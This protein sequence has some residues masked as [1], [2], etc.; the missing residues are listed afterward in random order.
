MKHNAL[1]IESR[2]GNFLVLSR[3]LEKMNITAT[4]VQ[5]LNDIDE[6]LSKAK[7]VSVAIIDVVGYGDGIWDC[8][9]KFNSM[10][11]PM[12]IISPGNSPEA[13]QAGYAHGAKGVF[14]KPVLM[15]ELANCI[16]S[17][18]SQTC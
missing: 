5:R 3:F 17:L 2:P 10:G 12:L 8:C 18:V 9:K 15:H 14:K 7:P 11:I 13:L 1:T 16:K 4:H 6:A